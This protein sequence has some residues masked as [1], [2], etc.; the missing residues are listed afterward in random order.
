MTKWKLPLVLEPG[1]APLSGLALIGVRLQNQRHSCHRAASQLDSIYL[2]MRF[3][4]EQSV[5]SPIAALAF[6][7]GELMCVI[8]SV[9]NGR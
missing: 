7:R 6:L 4:C 8:D 2:L 3:L 1:A 9:A 5:R